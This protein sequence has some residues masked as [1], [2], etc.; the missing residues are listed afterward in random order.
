MCLRKYPTDDVVESS[1]VDA[2][3]EVI[4]SRYEWA[5]R[6]GALQDAW[7]DGV[8]GRP[9]MAASDVDV[10]KALLQSSSVKQ[11]KLSAVES[12]NLRDFILNMVPK[13]LFLEEMDTNHDTLSVF[14]T[15]GEPGLLKN[16]P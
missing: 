2:L 16:S 4:R 5:L 10:S 14:I 3:N 11:N 8:L 9:W 7:D 6:R 15:R 1:I 13:Q 12:L